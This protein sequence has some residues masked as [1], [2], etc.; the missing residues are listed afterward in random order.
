M[1]IALFSLLLSYWTMWS[2]LIIM[3]NLKLNNFI[4]F[5]LSFPFYSVE[6]AFSSFFVSE[7]KLKTIITIRKIDQNW[8]SLHGDIRIC[9]TDWLLTIYSF[10]PFFLF[11][12]YN[13]WYSIDV[14]CEEKKKTRHFLNDLK[15]KSHID[16]V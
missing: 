16:R 5:C 4:G 6:K 13:F 8:I 12:C 14:K 7:N 1:F 10:M 2:D 9:C 3:T 15:D 11:D